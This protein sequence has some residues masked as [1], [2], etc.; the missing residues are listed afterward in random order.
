MTN[1]F[2]N[3]LNKLAEQHATGTVENHGNPIVELGVFIRDEMKRADFGTSLGQL[4]SSAQ[5]GLS[6]ASE[7]ASSHGINPAMQAALVGGGLGAAAGGGTALMN[8]DR[9]HHFLSSALTGGIAGAA[10][11]GGGALAYDK[12]MNGPVLGKAKIDIGNG[13]TAE[14]NPEQL[15][16]ASQLAQGTSLTEKGLLG[17]IGLT[18]KTLWDNAPVTTSLG[19]PA[20]GYAGYRALADSGSLGPHVGKV[21]GSSITGPVT[22][23]AG[24][25]TLQAMG[26]AM[27]DTKFLPKS[28]QD[29]LNRT[30][31]VVTAANPGSPLAKDLA[32]AVTNGA[33]KLTPGLQAA[34]TK[35]YPTL[36]ADPSAANFK[37]LQQDI[38]PS[39]FAE[40]HRTFGTGAGEA[41]AVRKTLFGKF[42]PMGKPYT[43][44]SLTG[45]LAGLGIAGIG[46]YGTRRLYEENQNKKQLGELLT[47]AAQGKH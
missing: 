9:R 45:L 26:E 30:K 7:W 10:L 43:G 29:I 11:G 33:S 16:Q 17:G 3:A 5:T 21:I 41:D 12:V 13:Q 44:K 2:T 28:V 20:L 32:N 35:H 19:A 25:P 34:V 23:G 40:L 36:S 46:E 37:L 27:K 31:S 18:A 4:A 22:G 42:K 15:A 14:L 1:A 39:G 6:N 47:A 24:S 8:P 38:K